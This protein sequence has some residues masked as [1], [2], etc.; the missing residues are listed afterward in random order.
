LKIKINLFIILQDIISHNAAK[1]D[2][3]HV[4]DYVL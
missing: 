4:H 1:S 2:I 3:F